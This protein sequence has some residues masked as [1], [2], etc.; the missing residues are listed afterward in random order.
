VQRALVGAERVAEIFATPA[1]LTEPVGLPELPTIKGHVQLHHVTFGYRPDRPVLHDVTLEIR[2]GQML[3][4]IGASGAGKTTVVSLL[5]NYYDT[6]TG[7]VLL[8]GHP[9]HHFDRDSSRR[10]V[11]AVLQEPM[12]FNASIRTTS[13]TDGSTPPT[14]R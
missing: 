3:A 5:C 8:D 12:L 7:Q 2:P 11:A 4:L 14:P 13:A 1:G 9:L 6:D 10:Q